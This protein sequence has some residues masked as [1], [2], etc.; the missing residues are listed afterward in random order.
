VCESDHR[1]R[2]RARQ[3]ILLRFQELSWQDQ[4]KT[5]QVIQ[6]Y[7]IHSGPGSKALREL[8]E[9]AECVDA[10]KQVAKHLGLGEGAAPGVQEYERA[11][12]ALGIELNAAT[13]VRR[14]AVWR[15]VC[16]AARGE[17]VSQT[18]RQRAQFRAAIKHRPTNTEEWL[19]GIREWFLDGA[20]SPF[21]EDD[22]DAWRQ[23]RNE[24]KANL[25]PVAKGASIRSAFV[26]PWSAVIK[27]AKREVSL[28]VA[29]SRHLKRL[30]KEGGDEFVSVAGVALILGTTQARVRH[31]MKAR[32]LP[33][34]AFKADDAQV[35]RLIDIEAHHAGEPVPRR[36]RGELQSQILTSTD[37]GDLCGLTKAEMKRGIERLGSRIP[38]PAGHVACRNYWFRI[39][40][41]V[42]LDARRNA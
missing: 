18:V 29:Q 41:E 36:K 28:A 32:G 22:Y 35:W 31:L 3:D 7:F 37:V 20:H 25:P 23:E 33:P 19:A 38:P 6:G 8:R 16:K 39:S 30:K 9:R 12:T 13:I 11:R 26:L 27:V 2:S 5:Y 21:S 40:V 17:K 34:Y 14:W 4:Y 15:E 24:Q 42:W 1:A 10:V